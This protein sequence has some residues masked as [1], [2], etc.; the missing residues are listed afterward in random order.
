MRS[1]GALGISVGTSLALEQGNLMSF[2]K[3]D[4]M[5]FNL[6]TLVRNAQESYDKDDEN[7]YSVDQ[8]VKDVEGDIT[9]LAKY[10]DTHRNGKPVKMIV[11]NPSYKGMKSKFPHADIKDHSKGTEKQQKVYKTITSVCDKLFEKYEKLIVPTNV[12]MPA[13]N[14]NGVV[15]THHPVDLCETSGTGRLKLFES[16]TGLLK[17]FPDWHTKLTNGKNMLNIPLNHLTIQ[18]F[19]DNSTDFM[20]SKHNIKDLVKTIAHDNNWTTATTYSRVRSTIIN[21][22]AGVDRAGLMMMF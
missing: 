20:S 21:M 15:M 17:S 8:L 2:R 16:Y 10:I 5:L 6:R 7:R 14:G 11:Y 13:F 9:F 4:S 12:G 1:T 3:I 19:G 22:T 18:I